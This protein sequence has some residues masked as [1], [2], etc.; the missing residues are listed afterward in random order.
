VGWFN[1]TT[2]KLYV[3]TDDTTGSASWA[4]LNTGTIGTWENWTPSYT[5]VGNTPTGISTVARYI[6]L[7]KAV[8]FV[9]QVSGTVGGIADLTDMSASL[10]ALAT[11]VDNN[12]LV[13]I[14][15]FRVVGAAYDKGDMVSID[16]VVDPAVLNHTSFTTIS[17][18]T[19]FTLYFS[20]Y[21]ETE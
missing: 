1:T 16:S 12:S 15:N 21:Y 7:G 9:L 19:T 6:A 2:Q 17:P 11:V 20:G 8:Y 14:N 18:T 4:E 10:P 3:L 5:W 13:P